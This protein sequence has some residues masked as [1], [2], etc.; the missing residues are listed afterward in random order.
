[1]SKN[2][3]RYTVP[4]IVLHWLIS[5][6]I[7]GCFAVG[8]YMADLRL[9]PTKL[10]LYS[11]HKWAGITVLGLAVLRLSWRIFNQP[12]LLPD[13]MQK[14]Q[15][16]IAT[17]LHHLLYLPM[18]LIPLSGWLMSSAKGYQVVYFGLWPLPDLMSKNEAW[19]EYLEEIHEFLNYG[20]IVLVIG[21]AAAALK[22]HFID[23]DNVL[24]RMLPFLKSKSSSKDH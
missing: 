1:M 15:K 10:K 3:T 22:H 8:L 24:I 19:G 21:H 18:F 12:P 2:P 9:S 4:A 5:I 13:A 20:M 23:K 16:S 17:G 7:L 11:W 14:W 6:M